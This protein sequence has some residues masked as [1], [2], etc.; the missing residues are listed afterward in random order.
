MIIEIKKNDGVE[1]LEKALSKL[2]ARARKTKKAS[3]RKRFF[4]MLKRDL[5]GIE[6]QKEKRNEWN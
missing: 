3:G 2:S 5:D 1:K 6:Y 4:G